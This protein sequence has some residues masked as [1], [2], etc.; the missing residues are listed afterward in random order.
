[1]PAAAAA[2]PSL[3]AASDAVW[4]LRS[5]RAPLF[6]SKHRRAGDGSAIEPAALKG[7]SAAQHV[8]RQP[9]AERQTQR[10]E[11]SSTLPRKFL[12]GAKASEGGYV[13]STPER[14]GDA[15]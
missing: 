1:V 6:F 10:F 15:R 7:T 3:E 4:S 12:Q 14:R 9:N 5:D 2:A 8:I 11:L 13:L